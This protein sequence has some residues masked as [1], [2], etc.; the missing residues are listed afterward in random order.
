MI[1]ES[2]KTKNPTVGIALL[3]YNYGRFVDAAI[4]SLK[5]QTFQDFE[6]FLIDDGSDDGYTPEKL[7][8]IKYDKIAKKLLHK[9][10]I[11]NAERRRRQ[12]KIMSNK[13]I[14]DMSADDILAPDFLEKTVSFLDNNPEYGAVSV[15]IQLFSNSID[16]AYAEK[17]FDRT[18]MDLKHVLARNQILGSSLMR[19]QALDETDLSGGFVRYQDWDRWISMMEAGW[20]IGLVSEPLFYYRQ[21]PGSLSHKASVDDELEIREKLLTK[22]KDSYKKYYKEV[23]L[24]M[25]RAFLEVLQGKNWL[26]EQYNQMGREIKRLKKETHQFET[27]TIYGVARRGLKRM[28]GHFNGKN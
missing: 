18:K 21:T 25:E 16:D 27:R 2:K 11:G 22:H 1:S 8:S 6:V 28:K 19:K 26:E 3:A 23:I 5:T 10:N 12:Y 15:N 4:A 13:Y 7:E 14:L 20:K 9:K 17:D 24:E